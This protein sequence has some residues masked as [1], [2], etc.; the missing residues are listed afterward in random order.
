MSSPVTSS[1]EVVSE[2][3]SAPSRAL[4]EVA[5]KGAL[6]DDWTP[7]AR[8]NLIA[9]FGERLRD[10]QPDGAKPHQTHANWLIHDYSPMLSNS[11]SRCACPKSTSSTTARYCSRNHESASLAATTV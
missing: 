10:T 2:T 8:G 4:D 7:D 1:G 3:P 9:L 11:H 6:K 5:H